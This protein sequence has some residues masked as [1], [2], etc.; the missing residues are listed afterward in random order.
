MCA[1]VWE[2]RWTNLRALRMMTAIV[3]VILGACSTVGTTSIDLGRTPYNQVIHETSE[4]QA[5]LNIVRVSNSESPLFMDVT[6]VDAAT[7][8]QGSISGG[9]SGL[10]ASPNFKGSAGTIA[11]AVGFITGAAQYQEAPTVRYLPLS[12]QPL[13]AQVSTPLTAE[14]LANLVPSDWSLA[15][16]LTLP[17]DRLTPGYSDYDAA[18]NAIVDLDKYGAIII[19]AT[20]SS[21]NEKKITFSGLTFNS[22]PPAT[23]DSLTIYYEPHHI[24]IAQAHCDIKSSGKT[25]AEQRANAEKTVKALWARLQ[26]IFHS[27]GSVISLLSKGSVRLVNG[28]SRPPLLSTRSALGILKAAA[29]NDSPTIAIMDPEKV[30]K[31]IGQQNARIG[32]NLCNDEFYTLDPLDP[33]DVPSRVDIESSANAEDQ[34]RK[35]A[36]SARIRDRTRSLITMYPDKSILS[37]YELET[38]KYLVNAR[39]FH[40]HS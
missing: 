12:G 4:Q 30:K 28:K 7:T 32:E 5:L 18:V 22:S 9:P 34:A 38:E 8:F 19:A 27:T 13:I 40:A 2:T 14:A 31:I 39:R 35:S 10:G 17:I 15:A 11:G 29:E 24:S 20:Q 33:P 16:V 26:N 36:I 25:D 23:K 21:D 6:E 3:P 37:S 1:L